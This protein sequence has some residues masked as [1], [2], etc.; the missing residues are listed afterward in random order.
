MYL[1]I[2]IHFSFSPYNKLWGR[3]NYSHCVAWK[4]NW[5]TVKGLA[6]LHYYPHFRDWKTRTELQRG[7]RMAKSHSQKDREPGLNLSIRSDPHYEV[8]PRIF[9]IVWMLTFFESGKITGVGANGFILVPVASN[10]SWKKWW[11]LSNRLSS[12]CLAYFLSSWSL[13]L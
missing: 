2:H 1:Y 4:E 7:W 3:Y 10:K 12:R 8:L 5:V 11:I 13:G 6:K 9:C